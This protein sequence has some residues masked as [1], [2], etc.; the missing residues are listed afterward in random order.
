MSPEDADQ[1]RQLR[2]AWGPTPPAPPGLRGRVLAAVDAGATPLFWRRPGFL[3]AVAVGALAVASLVVRQVMRPERKGTAAGASG[4]T[5][6]SI[7][8][9]DF[10]DETAMYELAALSAE[11]AKP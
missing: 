11:P 7:G 5:W 8:D 4:L 6:A 10:A 1:D 2:D 9:E 3:V